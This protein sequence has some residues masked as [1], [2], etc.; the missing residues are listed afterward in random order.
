MEYLLEQL[1]RR[2]REV[3]MWLHRE[4][5]GPADVRLVREDRAEAHLPEFDDRDCPLLLPGSA[6]AEPIDATRWLRF[7]LSRPAEWPMEETALVAEHF[8]L[9]PSDPQFG[10]ARGLQRMQGLVYLDGRPYHGLDHHHLRIFLPEGPE[11]TFAVKLWTGYLE[12]DYVPAPVFRLVR[13]DHEAMGL[14]H[15]LRVLHDALTHLATTHPARLDLERA[16]EQALRAIDWGSPGSEAFRASLACARARTSR[17]LGALRAAEYEPTVTAAG[18]SHIDCAW[19]WTIEQTREKAGRTWSTVLRLME[20]Y[21]EYRFLA[22]TPLQYQMV[23]ERFPE[24][25]EGIRQRVREGRW[26]PVGGMWV[27]ADCNLPDGESLARQ[28]L[29]G[30]RFFEREFG[31]NTR[32]GWLPD[33]FGFSWALPTLMAAARMPYFVTHKMSWNDTNRIPHDTFRWRGPDG[34]EVLAHFLC[35][36]EYREQQR[37]TYNATIL[38]STM[39]GAWTRF[40]DRSLQRELLCAFGYGDGGGGPSVEMLEAARRLADLPGFPRVRMGTAGGFF[41]RLEASLAGRT[42]V[43]VWD[44]ELYL[45]YHRGTYTSQAIQK[46]RNALAQRLYHAAEL[47]ASMASAVLDEPYPRKPLDEGWRLILTNQFHD[48]LPGSAIAQVYDDAE[49]DFRRLSALGEEVLERSLARLAGAIRL[50][51][52]ALVIFNPSPYPSDGYVELPA[53]DDRV[54]RDASGAPLPA[55]RTAESSLLVYCAEVPANGYQAFPLGDPPEGEGGTTPSLIAVSPRLVETPFWRIE[56]DRVGR[57]S[58]L[59]DK[60]HGRDALAPGELG[61]RLVVYEDKPLE[62]DAWEVHA[63]INE[64]PTE[65]DRLE[66]EAASGAADVGTEPVDDLEAAR[67]L[68]HGP[69]RGVLRLR[70]RHGRS[71][72]LQ[73]LTVYARNPRIDFV[74]EVEWRERQSL[75]KVGFPAAVRSRRA[76]YEIQFGTIDRPAHRNTS[77]DKAMFE[78]PAQRWADL[79]DAHYGLALLADCKHGY[80]ATDHTLWIS[81]I[82]SPIDPDPNADLGRHRFTY[83]L[84]PHPAGLEPVRR[85]AYEL[86]RPLVWR[87]EG[88]HPGPLPRAL[89]LASCE[90]GGVLVETAKWAE[91]EDA[92]V[93]RLYEADGGATRAHLRLGFTPAGV[94]EV[95]LLERDARPVGA[96]ERLAL[97]V[98]AREVK[99]LRVRVR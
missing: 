15:D 44:G 49:A 20:R 34:G 17:A 46:L 56:L 38:P 78:V 91:D 51:S 71:V 90:E 28:I 55:Q 98:R 21:P 26:E 80:N 69:E 82:K 27:E 84:L 39:Q 86:T 50:D 59:W 11:Y 23:K 62:F 24:T 97:D 73:W 33:T 68:E 40:Q 9:A 64:K 79:S 76:T 72:I 32:V 58:R 65:I 60:R 7:R 2:V 47:Y 88:A 96:G 30:T 87:R 5:G 70:W 6:W 95:T 25:Y 43:P 94:D 37:S 13:V 41:E 54:P 45:E 89:S 93:L 3:G 63:F 92:L 67:V 77:W 48:I 42:D 31:V 14:Y 57:I 4:R 1:E 81:L 99:T 61:N 35:T 75:L 85:A 52:D 10:V 66:A 83:S 12:A 29:V 22:S 36:P 16:A 74:T 8:A 18:H 53:G 19:L